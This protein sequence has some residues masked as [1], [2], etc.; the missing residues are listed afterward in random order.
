MHP[1]STDQP[2]RWKRLV[3]IGEIT[4]GLLL[5]LRFVTSTQLGFAWAPSFAGASAVLYIAFS[6][7]LWDHLLLRRVGIV[8]VPNLEGAWRGHLWTSYNVEDEEK[9]ADIDDPDDDLTAMETEIYIEQTWD[10]IHIGL[11]GPDSESTSDGATI[12]V[13]DGS[14][15]TLSYTYENDPDYAAEDNLEYHF[16]TTTVTYDKEEE[17]LDGYYYTGKRR[18]NYGKLKLERVDE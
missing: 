18:A 4:A 8:E 14:D 15:P 10:M 17:T 1:Y 12:H 13:N 7:F 6:K 3:Q 16:G 9:I 2:Y 11:D 5:I